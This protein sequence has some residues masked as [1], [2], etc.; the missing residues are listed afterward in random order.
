[1]TAEAEPA[2][3]AGRLLVRIA[4]AVVLIAV[5]AGLLA[6][7]TPGVFT[8]AVL[9]GVLALWELQGISEH[10]G[11]PAPTWLLFPLG[12]YLM[13]SGTAL[14][15]LP[16]EAALA[17]ALLAGLTTYL[18]LPGRAQGLGRWALGLGCAIYIGL[19]IN[20][21]LLLYTQPR[22]GHGIWWILLLIGSL[23][24]EDAAALLFGRRFGRRPFF[25]SI[26]PKKTW[27]GAIAGFAVGTGVFC[28][29]VSFGLQVP[30]WHGVAL[31]VLVA[32]SGVAGDLVESQVKRA[33][34]IKD[35]SNLIP[36]HG[37]ILDRLDSL[38]FGPIAVFLYASLFHL[39]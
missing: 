27:E 39:L 3:G 6:L 18:F 33:A 24:L 30:W 22:A 37:G 19:P 20:Y 29:G 35:S 13:F 4:S 5:A 7:G 34:G 14:R 21:Y 1:M 38:L 32:L 16:V 11:M 36:G 8:L 17:V 26:S 9:A 28:L 15:W 31:G 23:A 12:L 25:P 10:L 2:P